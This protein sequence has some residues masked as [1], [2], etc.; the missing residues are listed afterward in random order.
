MRT[1]ETDI[2]IAEDGSLKLLSPLPAWLKP[3]RSH[4][5]LTVADATEPLIQKCVP[6]ATP[7]MMATRSEALAKLR[8]TGGLKAVIP[9][10]AAWQKE[11][12]EDKKLPGRE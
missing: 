5:L 12:R 8:A 10:P 9:D 6:K 1:L 2:E 4:V 11:I 7:E 3:G